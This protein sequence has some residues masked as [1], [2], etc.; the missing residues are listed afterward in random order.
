MV[1][2]MTRRALVCRPAR[3]PV[4]AAEGTMPTGRGKDCGPTADP[5][6]RVVNTPAFLT[7]RVPR[8]P[9]TA[10][11]MVESEVKAH[12]HGARNVCLGAE[13]HRSAR[14]DAPGGRRTR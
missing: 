11:V 7:M 6:G 10:P 2:R 13:T 8:F 5:S 3:R 4:E 12:S 1:R 9:F 14:P